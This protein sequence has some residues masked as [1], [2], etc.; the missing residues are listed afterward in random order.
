MSVNNQMAAVHG[1]NPFQRVEIV[2]GV[3]GSVTLDRSSGEYF[4][5]YEG[6]SIYVERADW[7]VQFLMNSQYGGLEQAILLRDGLKLTAD[8]KGFTLSHP[9]LNRNAKISLMIGKNGADYDN[10]LDTPVTRLLIPFRIAQNIGTFADIR[11]YIFPGV[12]SIR[13]LQASCASA[14]PLTA[15][16]C[17][18]VFYDKNNAVITA[19]TNITQNIGGTLVT[20]N[21]ASVNGIQGTTIVGA[22]NQTVNFPVIFIPTNAVE[23]SVS[24]NGTAI[25]TPSITGNYE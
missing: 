2:I 19:T 14:T 21:G 15:N 17:Y 20:Y 23:M 10:S 24:L 16:S 9:P 18:V 4:G 6:S 11:A 3:D 22:N 5:Q 8:F 1:L 7:P 13:N 12:R 25:V